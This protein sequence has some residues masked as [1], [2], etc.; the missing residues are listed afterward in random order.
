MDYLT[1]GEMMGDKLECGCNKAFTLCINCLNP[2]DRQTQH[3]MCICFLGKKHKYTN[4]VCD[5][6][7]VYLTFGYAPLKLHFCLSH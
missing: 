4:C 1:I 5:L 6:R 7:F 3:K 2:V